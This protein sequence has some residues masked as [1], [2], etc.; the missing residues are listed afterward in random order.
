MIFNGGIGGEFVNASS[1]WP[2]S[3][4]EQTKLIQSLT[5]NLPLLR[6]KLDVT[7]EEISEIIGV[8]RQ[9]YSTI[10]SGKRTMSWQVYLSLVLFFDANSTT[11]NLLHHLE[12]FPNI[13][14]D[15][16]IEQEINSDDDSPDAS[17]EILRM[18]SKLDEQA[19]NSVKTVL[20]VE[21]ARCSK[22]PG[23]AVVKAFDGSGFKGTLISK[24]TEL[25]QAL[26]RI[27]MQSKSDES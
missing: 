2:L 23:E 27:K 16:T 19:L 9:T 1:R 15:K 25:N 10:E 24:D 4:T 13:L 14:I 22:I 8:S 26:D 18:L 7:Q 17:D 12:C 21:Y 20:M 3:K 11:H 5:K 6:A